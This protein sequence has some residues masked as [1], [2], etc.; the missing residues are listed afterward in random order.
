VEKLSLFCNPASGSMFSS[1]AIEIIN[2][3][4]FEVAKAKVFPH[5]EAWVSVGRGIPHVNGHN[6][7]LRHRYSQAKN[8]LKKPLLSRGIRYICGFLLFHETTKN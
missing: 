7:V 6:S 2:R 3:L 1:T 8:P 4:K 5:L